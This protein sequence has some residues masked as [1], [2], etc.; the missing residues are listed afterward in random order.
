MIDDPFGEVKTYWE[1]LLIQNVALNP[2]GKAV[3]GKGSFSC[4]LSTSP[5]SGDGQDIK[6]DTPTRGHK[7]LVDLLVFNQFLNTAQLFSVLTGS[8][9]LIAVQGFF[10]IWGGGE[11]TGNQTGVSS[12]HRW[13]ETGVSLRPSSH[14]TSF[15]YHVFSLPEIAANPT[16]H[17]QGITNLF[18]LQGGLHIADFVVIVLFF[19]QIHAL[20]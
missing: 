15:C 8:H 3:L 9:Y 20:S 12:R 13:G 18:S 1:E 10:V 6:Q 11:G 2:L 4:L 19:Q 17:L 14:L 16:R 5:G 7:W